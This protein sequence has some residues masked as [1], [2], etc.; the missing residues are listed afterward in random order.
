MSRALPD[1]AAFYDLDLDEDGGVGALRS[2]GD[3]P[4]SVVNFFA[5]HE[6]A[7]YANGETCTGLEAMM[8]Y[9]A[10]SGD[11]LAAAGGHFV[12]QALPTGVLW[13]D[14]REWDLLVVARYPDV[15]AFWTLLRDPAYQD[16]FEHRR[17]AVARQ[18]VTVGAAL[19]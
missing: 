3:A 13:G 2:I 9:G 11:R 15:D 6:V 16:A 18:R 1:I 10:I 5:L 14:D 7:R 12:T 4:V 19:W 8:R 17:A